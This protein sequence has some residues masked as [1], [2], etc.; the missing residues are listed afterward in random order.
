MATNKPVFYRSVTEITAR[1]AELGLA[2]DQFVTGCNRGVANGAIGINTG[3]FDPKVTDFAHITHFAGP[4]SYIGKLE[5][6]IANFEDNMWGITGAQLPALETS[7]RVGFDVAAGDTA[8]D[9]DYGT[10]PVTNYTG[11]TIPAGSWAWGFEAAGGAIEAP[12]VDAGPPLQFGI[13]DEP[14]N[15]T[16]M[17]LAGDVT[18]GTDPAPTYY[19]SILQGIPDDGNSVWSDRTSLTSTFKPAGYPLNA[20]QTITLALT[21]TVDD[22]PPVVDTVELTYIGYGDLPTVDAGG[23]YNYS[24]P[25]PDAIQLSGTVTPG[26]TPESDPNP[27]YTWGL[28]SGVDFTGTFDNATSLTAIFTLTSVGV[29]P[30]EVALIAFPSG[31]I[32]VEDTAPVTEV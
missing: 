7:T 5:E 6:A 17:Q 27:F 29:D 11:K 21:T 19:W 25:L 22:G 24:L 15:Y 12:I 16:M 2:S 14:F 26:Q 8:P 23:P 28:P 9:A 18:P 10:L 32:P 3:D 13:I 31:M 30:V 4:V 1:A 20:G